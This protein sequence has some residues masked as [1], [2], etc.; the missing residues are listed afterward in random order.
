MADKT[1]VYTLTDAWLA[2]NRYTAAADVD[3][4]IGNASV[5]HR[6]AFAI[7]DDNTAPSMAVGAAAIIKPGERE[8]MQLVT[9]ERLWLAYVDGPAF[10]NL[11]V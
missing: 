1:T 8:A 3:I 11:T 9:G 2:T 10:A 5:A 6:I 7:T 4:R